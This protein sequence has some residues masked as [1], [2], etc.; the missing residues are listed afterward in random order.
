MQ[1]RHRIMFS[2]SRREKIIAAQYLKI[3]GFFKMDA[4]QFE[5]PYQMG[6]NLQKY[7]EIESLK[8]HFFEMIVISCLA[9][10][11]ITVLISI[12]VLRRITK[13]IKELEQH[14]NNFNN[15]LSKINLKGDVSIEILSLQNHFNE[16][17]DKIKYLREYEINALYSQ[18]NPHFLYNTLDT[19]IWMAEFQ[20]TEKVISITK[21]L[22]NF[23][24]ISLSN[25]KEKIPLK[26]EINHI[27]EYLYIQIE[28]KANEI[29]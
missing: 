21:A 24:R 11:L 10:L 7:Q 25:G 15:D 9:S 4:K 16:M 13:P 22:S 18:I 5:I 29:I 8:N 27:K 14:M 23:F 17:I 2:D 3:K 26:E 20:D 12:S 1:S 19:I 28:R 6:I